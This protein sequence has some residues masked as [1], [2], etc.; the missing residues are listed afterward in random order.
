MILWIFI[1]HNHEVQ[2]ECVYMHTSTV[3]MFRACEQL[4][5]VSETFFKTLFWYPEKIGYTTW[6]LRWREARTPRQALDQKPGYWC[7]HVHR[8]MKNQIWHVPRKHSILHMIQ[9]K[10]TSEVASLLW[11][12]IFDRNKVIVYLIFW[13]LPCWWLHC[14]AGTEMHF[15]LGQWG[16]DPMGCSVK[17]IE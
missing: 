4:I 16:W 11:K 2:F 1:Q 7:V 13:D 8:D 5:L 17:D 12:C 6:K 3:V 9:T 15:M 14:C 10:E